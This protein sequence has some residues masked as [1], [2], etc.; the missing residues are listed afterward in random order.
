MAKDVLHPT[1]VPVPDLIN[2]LDVYI[3]FDNCIKISFQYLVGHRSS[4]DHTIVIVDDDG[5]SDSAEVESLLYTTDCSFGTFLA[6]VRSLT[7]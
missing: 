7:L 2:D 6:E 1:Q 3:N 4:L 5:L